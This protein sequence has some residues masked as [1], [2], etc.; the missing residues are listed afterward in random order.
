MSDPQ[1][2]LSTWLRPVLWRLLDDSDVTQVALA[3]EVGISPKHLNQMLQGVVGI[4]STMAARLL[5]AFGYQL[6]IG[7]TAVIEEEARDDH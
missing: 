3:E 1:D 5:A 4:G 7:M 2:P 6:A